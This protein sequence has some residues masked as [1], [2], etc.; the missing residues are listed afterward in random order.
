M[1]TVLDDNMTLCL[2]NGERIKLNFEMKCLFEVNDLV[3]VS[4]RR[5]L[6]GMCHRRTNWWPTMQTWVA[7]KLPKDTPQSVRDYIL[8]LVEKYMDAGIKWHEILQ[9]VYLP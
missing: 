7:T 5:R 9:G 1:N 3:V 2:A 4:T 8:W 6:I